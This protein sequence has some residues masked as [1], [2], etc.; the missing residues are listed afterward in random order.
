MFQSTVG[1]YSFLSQ[2]IFTDGEGRAVA[3]AKLKLLD[4]LSEISSA[5]MDAMP[6]LF[7]QPHA[8]MGAQA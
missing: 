2:L 4:P 5:V 3:G 1:L 8:G 6:E 7:W